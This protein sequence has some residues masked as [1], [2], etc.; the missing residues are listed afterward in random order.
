MLKYRNRLVLLG[1][2]TLFFLFF[3]LISYWT[4]L[5]GDD[6]GYA[7]NGVRNNPFQLA[8]QFYFT[9]SGRF[10]SELWGFLIAPNK[11]L[12]NILNPLLFTGIAFLI[13]LLI[14][15]KV[16]KIS[17]LLLIFFL[18][19]SVKDYVRMETY[20]W[21]MGTTYVAPLFLYLLYLYFIKL[22]LLDYN[23]S[24]WLFSSSLALN[25]IIP[26][27]MENIATTLIFSNILILIYIYFSDKSRFRRHT[28]LL[29]SSLISFAI[30]R[31]SPGSAY[32]LV[33]EHQTW[34]NLS[35]IEQIQENWPNFLTYTFLDNKY[36][37]LTLSIVFLGT[38]YSHRFT[39][40]GKNWTYIPLI[41]IFSLG[42]LQSSSA[43]IYSVWKWDIL[44]LFFDLSYPQTQGLITIFYTLYLFAALYTVLYFLN[45]S[46]QWTS[47]FLILVGGS[48]TVVMLLSPIFGARSSLY[49][50]Y[51]FILLTG[52]L[53]NSL[54]I[55]ANLS[56]SIG[57]LLFCLC[58]LWGKS[59]YDKYS[60]VH[61]KQQE[62]LD[63]IEWIQ[64]NPQLKEA[65]IERMP[66]LTVHS[67]DIE[68]W[69]TYHQDVFKEYYNLNPN[70][71]LIFYWPE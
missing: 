3:A 5:A 60:L 63:R 52:L 12:W 58:L 18:M 9:W 39:Y 68:D 30:L 16:K 33:T 27:W 53:Y 36:L 64:D 67:A 50:I 70:L 17:T 23:T 56:S 37:L 65:W 42:I 7:V 20:T 48:S 47:L 66:I 51:I 71:K 61:Q 28:F 14:N 29:I 24:I 19:L 38:L 32:R 22:M 13:Y 4:P 44:L 35:L 2:F 45:D 49:F 43:F 11:W 46:L 69:D 31:L 25:F 8:Y 15:P 57:F 10:F 26:L 21:I 59:Y 40:K 55:P 41:T 62:R 54:D 34:L 6:W 1:L